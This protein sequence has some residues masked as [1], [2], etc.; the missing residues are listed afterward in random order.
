[1]LPPRPWLLVTYAPDQDVNQDGRLPQIWQL[2][3]GTTLDLL[4][5]GNE[6]NASPNNTTASGKFVQ[7]KVQESLSQA[8]CGAT[9]DKIDTVSGV[10]VK[11]KL[12]SFGNQEQRPL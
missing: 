11:N 8:I 5:S 7:G 12:I 6:D 10:I 9:Q 1:M 2:S 4:G 3:Q